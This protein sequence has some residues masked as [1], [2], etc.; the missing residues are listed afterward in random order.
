M[1]ELLILGMHHVQAQHISTCYPFFF[2]FSSFIPSPVM[3][4]TFDHDTLIFLPYLFPF[5]FP[6][7]LC[8]ESKRGKLNLVEDCLSPSCT[9][10][11]SLLFFQFFN[12]GHEGKTGFGGY[13]GFH[14]NRNPF[15]SSFLVPL[16]EVVSHSRHNRYNTAHTF[17]QTPS[18]VRMDVLLTFSSVVMADGTAVIARMR[19]VVSFDLLSYLFHFTFLVSSTFLKIFSF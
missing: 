17:L 15:L 19:L 1:M 14:S 5:F 11:Y 4:S 10:L 6:P 2:L 12:V 7:F 9:I 13:L 16:C 18:S 3:H 8:D